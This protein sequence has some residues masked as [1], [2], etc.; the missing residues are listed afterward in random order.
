MSS[1]CGGL[2]A[3]LDKSFAPDDCRHVEG[4]DVPTTKQECL[5]LR[6]PASLLNRASPNMEV[7][8][9]TDTS[10]SKH[11]RVPPV[12]VQHWKLM[13]LFQDAY[14]ESSPR[15]QFSSRVPLGGHTYGLSLWDAV[16]MGGHPH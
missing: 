3:L 7:R 10:L 16:H 6:R 5:R 4:T 13:T 15:V 8:N 1:C 9:A 11:P 12:G 2:R 14:D